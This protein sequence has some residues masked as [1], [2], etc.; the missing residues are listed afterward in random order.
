[1]TLAT[2]CSMACWRET[3]K[4]RFLSHLKSTAFHNVAIRFV[5]LSIDALVI[6]R[7]AIF[8]CAYR[9]VMPRRRARSILHGLISTRGHMISATA[10]ALYALFAPFPWIVRRAKFARAPMLPSSSLTAACSEVRSR[11]SPVRA[12]LVMPSKNS[13]SVQRRR[14]VLRP[15]RFVCRRE[16]NKSGVSSGAHSAMMSCRLFTKEKLGRCSQNCRAIFGCWECWEM[17]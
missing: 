14:F 4:R 11:N 6:K 7:A 1:M 13:V 10:C 8:K 15:I 5:E 2:P 9:C 12:A 3:L 16:T 17:L